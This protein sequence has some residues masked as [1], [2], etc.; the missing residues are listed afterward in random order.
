[1]M[2]AKLLPAVAALL[3]LA[4]WMNARHCLAESLPLYFQ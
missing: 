3:W 2:K 4:S 1:M